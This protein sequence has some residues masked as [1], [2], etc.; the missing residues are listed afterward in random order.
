MQLADNTVSDSGP[1]I[2]ILIGNDQVWSY[3]YGST[4][5]GQSGSIAI[6][7]KLRYILS[8]PIENTLEGQMTLHFHLTAS[9]VLRAM[10]TVFELTLYKRRLT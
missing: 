4:V 6:E 5:Q 7:S 9:R 3:I 2:T 1:E 8:G 10:A